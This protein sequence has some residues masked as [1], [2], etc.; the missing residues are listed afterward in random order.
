MRWAAA[1]RIASFGH[2]L[3]SFLNVVNRISILRKVGLECVP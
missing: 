1:K 3:D 2:S